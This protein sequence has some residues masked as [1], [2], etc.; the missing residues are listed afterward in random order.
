ME[1]PA[2]EIIIDE[3]LVRSLLKEQHPDL[4]Q[5]DLKYVAEGWDNKIY[6][7]GQDFLIRLPRRQQALPYIIREQEWLP[8]LA[9][10]LPI[11]IPSP[12]RFGQAQGEYPWPWS[13]TPWFPGRPAAE[14]L[15][16]AKEAPR[17]AHFLKKLHHPPAPANAPHNA[18]RG[19]T[20]NSRADKTEAR[21]ER[22]ISEGLISA[23]ISEIWEEALLALDEQAPKHL[24]H[25]DLHPK[26]I[27]THQG[28]FSA[29]IDWGDIT[30]G[31][32][33]TDL[34]SFWMLFSDQNARNIGLSDYGTHPAL[35]AR[36]KGWAVFFGTILLDIG[37]GGD[38]IFQK[39]GRFTLQNLEEGYR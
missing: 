24:I 19:C 23:N 21:I 29:I 33:A 32:P 9:P 27:I 36:A 10:S 14:A 35:L 15:P 5:L 16:E 3:K 4:A 34:A 39:V 22:F 1:T 38:P 25:G 18:S 13:I 6:K 7:L 30:A 8:Q 26:N 28:K 11:P 20:L 2:A 12:I 31:D 17:F 37:L